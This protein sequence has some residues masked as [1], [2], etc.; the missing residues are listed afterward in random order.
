VWPVRRPAEHDPEKL[1]V[2]LIEAFS[3]VER[4]ALSWH[5]S[6]AQPPGH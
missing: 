4:F 3:V 1:A 5:C 2:L 6:I